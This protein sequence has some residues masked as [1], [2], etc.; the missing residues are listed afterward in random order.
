MVQGTTIHIHMLAG[1]K[2]NGLMIH[3]CKW[4]EGGREGTKEEIREVKNKILLN[5]TEK[6]H[7][8]ES[9]KHRSTSASHISLSLTHCTIYKYIV[10]QHV[11]GFQAKCHFSSA[12]AATATATVI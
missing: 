4:T 2:M 12:A 7:K 6:T 8:N 9:K 3:R 10:S 1:K 5:F 11:N